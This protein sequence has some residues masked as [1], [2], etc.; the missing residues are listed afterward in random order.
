NRCKTKLSACSP[1]SLTM[2]R[3][4]VRLL[5]GRSS[6]QRAC[7]SLAPRVGHSGSIPTPRSS[8]GTKCRPHQVTLADL[9]DLLAPLRGASGRKYVELILVA[10]AD[11]ASLL[12]IRE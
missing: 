3:T 12:S 1:S 6:W 7:S 4:R 8:K 9:Q 11:W 10:Y 2:N 5:G